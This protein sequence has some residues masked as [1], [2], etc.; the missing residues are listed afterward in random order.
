MPSVWSRSPPAGLYSIY[1]I[2]PY[3]NP[4]RRV[5]RAAAVTAGSR[6][7]P[8]VSPQ[9]TVHRMLDRARHPSL[10]SQRHARALRLS[11][12]VSLS[13]SLFLEVPPFVRSSHQVHSRRVYILY[14]YRSLLSPVVH[15]RPR[16]A[17]RLP[18]ANDHFFPSPLRNCACG[19]CLLW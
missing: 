17:S 11:V 4:P 13:L 2:T 7:A 18:G 12:S 6:R 14:W 19:V 8:R 16:P 10:N 9:F 15:T 3:A 5:L 1:P